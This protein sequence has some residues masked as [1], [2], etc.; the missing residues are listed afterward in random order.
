VPNLIIQTGFLGD[1]LLCLPLMRAVRHLHAAE[2]LHVVCRPGL[3]NLLRELDVCDEVFELKKGGLRTDP[4]T[5]KALR[6]HTYDWVLCPHESVRSALLVRKLRANHKVGFGSWWNF[7]A[8]DTRIAR[9]LQLPDAARQYALSKAFGAHAVEVARNLA[10]RDTTYQFLDHKIPPELD[11]RLRAKNS[12]SHRRLVL[13]A[14]G[15]VWATKRW[16][17]YG[18]T[19]VAQQLVQQGFEVIWT[20]SADERMLCERLAEDVPGSLSRA[21]VWNWRQLLDAMRDARVLIGNDSGAMH[22]AAVAGCPI[23]AIFGATTLDLG[24]R[25]WSQRAIVVQKDL[26]CRPC[27]RHGGTKCPLGTLDCMKSVGVDE[28]LK[29]SLRLAQSPAP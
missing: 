19:Q 24:Y 18:Y 8:F 7:F 12:I 11:L 21:G 6:A 9:P 1:L 15:S 25:P 13:I 2:P 29:A 17:E 5:L 23:V 26:P 16:T 14:P 27:G 10:A 4:T 3:A 28:V 20:G 22:L